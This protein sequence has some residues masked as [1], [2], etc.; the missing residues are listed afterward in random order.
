MA[1]QTDATGDIIGGIFDLTKQWA[2]PFVQSLAKGNQSNQ[3]NEQA[4]FNEKLD[5]N[6]LNGSGPVDAQTAKQAPLS[7]LDFVTGSRT[8]PGAGA[9]SSSGMGGMI[10]PL[11]LIGVGGLLFFVVLKKV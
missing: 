10:V 3:A 11:V 2:T 4:V 5:W 1:E 7:L 9:A 6:A 8:N